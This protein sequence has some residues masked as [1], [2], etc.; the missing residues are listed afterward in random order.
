MS[1]RA[2]RINGLLRQEL[3][4]L[5]LKGIKDPRLSGVVSITNVSVSPDLRNAKVYLSV[6]GG[7]DI[8]TEAL[9]GMQSA[10][11]FLRREL[12]NSISLRYV[13]FLKFE[14][15]QSLE[16]STHLLNIL[17]SLTIETEDHPYQQAPTNIEHQT[18]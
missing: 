10:A 2:D 7:S 6:L 3:S 4:Q 1:R 11:S 9:A 15:D 8:K 16:D 5:I 12:R 14:L 18:N 13:P 17:D